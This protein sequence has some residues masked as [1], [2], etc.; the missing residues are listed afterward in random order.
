[1]KSLA[2]PSVVESIQTIPP[3]YRGK[4][5]GCRP[6]QNDYS[7]PDL[8]QQEAEDILLQ[9]LGM[10]QPWQSRKRTE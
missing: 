5:C 10:L 1:V 4:E 7:P 8:L 6:V 2:P 9:T 3:P